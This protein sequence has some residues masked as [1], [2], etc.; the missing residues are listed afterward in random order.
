MVWAVY[1]AILADLFVTTYYLLQPDYLKWALPDSIDG[2]MHLLIIIIIPIAGI[3]I[4]SIALRVKLK[5]I[6]GFY[7]YLATS[8]IVYVITF[9][10]FFI[11]FGFYAFPSSSSDPIS[12]IMGGVFYVSLYWPSLLVSLPPSIAV[13][14]AF[15]KANNLSHKA[16]DG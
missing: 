5:L 15:R 9:L 1:I 4:K 7:A 3:L 16:I 6:W 12:R 11:H 2:V 8:I 13:F 10:V 14:F